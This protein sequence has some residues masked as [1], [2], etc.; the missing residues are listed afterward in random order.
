[1]VNSIVAVMSDFKM[2]VFIKTPG[3]KDDNVRKEGLKIFQS[4]YFDDP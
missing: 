3:I 4:N 2:D 1:M